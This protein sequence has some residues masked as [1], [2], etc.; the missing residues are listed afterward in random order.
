MRLDASLRQRCK[1]LE[2]VRSAL[3]SRFAEAVVSAGVDGGRLTIGVAGTVWASRIR[4]C[5]QGSRSSLS[6]KLGIALTSVRIRVVPQQGVV[7][8]PPGVP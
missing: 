3:P 1:V 8:P 5:S 4:Y 7:P 6:E 2:E